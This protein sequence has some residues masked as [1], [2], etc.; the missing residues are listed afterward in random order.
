VETKLPTVKLLDGNALDVFTVLQAIGMQA[1][2]SHQEIGLAH[3]FAR[4]QSVK[5]WSSEQNIQWH[6]FAQGAVSRPLAHRINGREG[7]RDI[8]EL[9]RW[10]DKLRLTQ[11]IEIRQ[12]I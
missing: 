6:E 3:T 2:Y 1:I 5:S 9:E 7:Y 10:A 4:D 12:T 8:S 11:I